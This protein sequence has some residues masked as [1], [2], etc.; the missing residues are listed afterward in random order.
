LKFLQKQNTNKDIFYTK[1]PSG[2][3]LKI[4]N[5]SLIK[6]KIEVKCS[7]SKGHLSFG[8]TQKFDELYCVDASD[9]LNDKIII[10]KINEPQKIKELRVN[11]LETFEQQCQ[12]KR[13]PRISLQI[14]LSNLFFT[15][16]YEGN[17]STFF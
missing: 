3:L 13:R 15:K 10:Y 17:I 4:D 2:D 7:S 16:L 6:Y 8:P 11:K 14:L 9:F 5:A 12:Q 1:D